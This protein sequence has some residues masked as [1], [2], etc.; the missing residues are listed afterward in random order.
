MV[1]RKF[2]RIS[3]LFFFFFI[4]LSLFLYVVS[5]TLFTGILMV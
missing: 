3:V 1:L 4:F 2:V 5:M